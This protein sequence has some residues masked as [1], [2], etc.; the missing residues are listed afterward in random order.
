VT[1]SGDRTAPIRV[2]LHGISVYTHHGVTD[3]EQEVG[4]RLV[5]DLVLDVLGVEA[6]H[7]DELDGTVDYGVA[8]AI[9][10][11]AAAETSYRTLERLAQVIGERLTERLAAAAATVR[12]SKPEPP[13]DHVTG[14]ATVEVTVRAADA[15]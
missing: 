8:C 3:A 11:E 5:I 1:A 7:S 10:V 13:L 9:A 4:Q 12:V 15:A 6:T 14:A 2:E